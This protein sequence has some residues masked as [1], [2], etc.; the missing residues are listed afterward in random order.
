MYF[1]GAFQSTPL[2]EGRLGLLVYRPAAIMFQST[3]L[4]EG[5]HLMRKYLSKW[6]MFQSTP[7]CEGRRYR[8]T[9]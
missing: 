7:L 1:H 4:C 6:L 8:C 9:R 3:P 5:R 2:C